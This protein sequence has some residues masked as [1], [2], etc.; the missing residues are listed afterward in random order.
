MQIDVRGGPRRSR[1]VPGVGFGPKIH[2]KPCRRSPARLP[3]GSPGSDLLEL[4]E[5]RGF[6]AAGSAR[7]H[8]GTMTDA[9]GIK[10]NRS[11]QCGS[12]VGLRWRAVPTETDPRLENWV[13]AGS[14]AGNFRAGFPGNLGRHRPTGP[15]SDRPGPPRTSTCTKRQPRRPV[16][17]PCRGSQKSRQ[18]AF[19]HP[20][21]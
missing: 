2:G 7:S 20:G 11:R 5:R 9:G 3:S 14:L 6:P 16:L 12:P 10:F 1:G 8:F 13:P 15:P 19:R 18:T 17:R 21:E 4:F